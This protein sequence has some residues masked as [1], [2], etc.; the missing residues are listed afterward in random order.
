MDAFYASVEQRDD[1]SLR[2][3][4][5]LVGG[6]GGRGVVAAASYEARAFGA[7]S[8][9][10]MTRALRLCPEATCVR[11]RMSR[12]QAESRR[13]FAIF[14]TFTPVIEGLSLDEAF[15]DVSGSLALFGPPAELGRRIKEQV[16]EE[17]GLRASV[18]IGP[19][20]LVAKIAS[21]LEKPD[22][23]CV[24]FGDDIR[25]RLDP[26]PV[27]AISGIGPRTAERL[28]AEGVETIRDL[29]TAAEGRLRRVLGRHAARLQARAAGLDDRPVTPDRADISISSEE[30]FGEDLTDRA[31][32]LDV[33]R[34]QSEDVARRCRRKGLQAG[35]VTLKVRRS[36]FTTY[37]RQRRISPPAAEAAPIARVAAELLA[38]W[39]DDQG[40][41]AVRLLGVGVTALSE[42][43]QLGLFETGPGHSPLDETVASIRER[44]GDEAVR[45]EYRIADGDGVHRRRS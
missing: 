4:P 6:T 35:V 26:L 31:A 34:G 9:M 32:L 27:R 3:R 2:G 20:K 39:L 23:L 33:L 13:I 22:G 40:G 18:G 12:Y 42:A 37:S 38:R 14:E 28:G 16:F 15:L 5:V 29:R 44:F 10:P 8:A 43:N 30:T 17:T 45:T 1:P 24:L 7:R 11:P 36:D 19:N 21:D 41:A 25:A